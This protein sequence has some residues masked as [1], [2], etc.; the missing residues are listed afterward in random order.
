MKYKK[1]ADN[2][3]EF[4]RNYYKENNLKGVVIGISGGKDSGVVAGLF[5][6]ALGAENVLGVW[7]PCHSKDEDKRNAKLVSEHFG[8]ELKEFDLTNM[9][10][11]YVKQIKDN[12]EVDDEVLVDA[13]INVKPR[14]RTATL[15]YHAAMMS[16]IK[17]GGYIVAG[18]SN[19]CEIYVGYFT[20]GGDNVADIQ[21]LADLTVEEVIGVGKAIGVPKVVVN[22]IPDDGLSGLSDEEKLGVKY[23][24][25]A[26]VINGEKVAQNV[27]EKIKKLHKNNAH[28][29]KTPTFKKIA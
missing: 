7:M 23:D 16:K 11:N 14:M 17:K 8:F 20:K 10:E 6:K 22:K 13:N 2:I 4:I 26:K 15:Y 25:I 27:K 12:Y 21:V 9:Y 1:L 29:F 3:I 19:K 24:D 18:T 28:K 5:V